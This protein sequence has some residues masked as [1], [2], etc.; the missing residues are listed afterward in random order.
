MY[1]LSTPVADS[2]TPGMGLFLV[3]SIILLAGL[4]GGSLARLV[5]L[6]AVTGNMLAGLLIG[7]AVL[8]V[9]GGQPITSSLQP[10]STFAMALIAVL[11]GS[12]LSYRRIHNALQRIVAITVFEVAGAVLLV[13]LAMRFLGLPWPVALII[14]CIAAETAPATTV[15]II[16]E[17]RA[18]GPFVKTVLS[19]VAL[20]NMLCIMLF[21]FSRSLLADSYVGGADS[22][23]LLD[24]LGHTG[25]QFIASVVLGFGLGHLTERLVHRAHV[26]DFSAV[27]VTIF[28]CL[29]ISTYLGFSPLLSCLFFGM[30]LG[31]ASPEAARQTRALEPI[32]LLLFSCFFTIAGASVHLDMLLQAGVFSLVFLLARI[33][34]KSSGATL[35][36]IIG[37][38]PRRITANAGLAVVPQA[39][40]S[41]GLV[42]LLSGDARIP[43]E[44]SELIGTIILGAVAV[45]ELIGP[46]LTRIAL[47][48]VNEV[49]MDRRRLIEFLQEE[50]IL[51]G[52]SAKDKWDALRELTDFHCRT[53][54][55]ASEHRES[56]YASI[57][58]REQE[59][60]TAI[61]RGAAIPHGRVTHGGKVQGV[62]AICREGIDFDAPDGEPVR[63]IMLVVTPEGFEKEHL[64]V[65][66]SLAHL[67][68]NDAIRT[69][70]LAAINAYDA[71][72]IIE[73]EEARGHNYFL[74]D[75]GDEEGVQ[76]AAAS[77]H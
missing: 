60:S 1:A 48:R 28:L 3:L 74:E 14:G 17:M 69:R 54:H 72:E 52:L 41:I 71:W 22:S 34:G 30:Y 24:A 23:R 76:P 12:H 61:G 55:T 36:G 70:L 8:D 32:E 66:A 75:A 21:A 43:S 31:N 11:V 46:F 15:A 19:M 33:V 44:T 25:W 67:I 39:G 29:G 35:G 59:L 45:N 77:A 53:H 64:E 7:P 65:M 18:K 37:R 38:S 57:E 62:L 27:F 16:R 5:R 49:N 40:I 50:F 42:V 4:A 58:Q 13:T 51:V 73:S 6:P 56:L 9:F 20:D 10:L 63:L 47:A 2:A 26:H 68:A